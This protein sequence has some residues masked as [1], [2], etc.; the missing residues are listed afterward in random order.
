[1]EKYDR[2]GRDGWLRLHAAP[3]TIRDLAS[4][5][6]G[7]KRRRR[8]KLSL[9]THL[10]ASL[11]DSAAEAGLAVNRTTGMPSDWSSWRVERTTLLK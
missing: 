1:M 2:D 3:V 6:S 11:R 10:D 4:P 9:T 5:T 7:A 8:I